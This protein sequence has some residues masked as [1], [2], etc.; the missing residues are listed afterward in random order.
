[1]LRREKT[2]Y[3]TLVIFGFIVVVVGIVYNI[4]E[5]RHNRRNGLIN[6]TYTRVMTCLISVPPESRDRLYIDNC[7]DQATHAT[8]VQVERYG[9]TQP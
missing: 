9:V 2:A 1:M 5:T 8:G 7:Y 3:I 6:Q 4:Q